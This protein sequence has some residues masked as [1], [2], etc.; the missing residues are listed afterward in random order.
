MQKPH[1]DRPWAITYYVGVEQYVMGRYN[2][3]AD[4]ETTI[5]KMRRL[6]DYPLSIIWDGKIEALATGGR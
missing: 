3:R 2:S 5:A 4:A 1:P 6:I